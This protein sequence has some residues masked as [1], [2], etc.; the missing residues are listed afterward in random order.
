MKIFVCIKQVPDTEAKIKVNP[1][2]SG[3]DEAGIKWVINPYDE[4]AIEEALKLKAAN[5]GS[6]VT[7]ASLGPK[8]RVIDAIRTGLA[9]GADDG[10]V[11]DAED[12]MDSYTVAKALSS[13]IKA[14]GDAAIIFTGR[15]AIDS[16]SASFSQQLAD[17]MELPHATVVS[18]FE[19]ADGTFTVEREV[20]GGSKEVIELKGACVVGANKGL[21]TPRYASLPGIMKAK[22]KPLKEVEFSSLGVDAAEQK[23]KFVDYKMPAD[24]P[25]VQM[26]DGDFAAQAKSL[27][28][29]LREEAKV[30]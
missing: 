18:K 9:M 13:A 2:Q 26:L 22:K 21:N 19:A 12:N 24:K 28:T 4:Y 10:L 20:E 6:T 30:I 7:I 23:I 11:I 25:A 3:I 5:A 27:V 15:Q 17:F 1:D 14:E 16:N 29:K 8:K